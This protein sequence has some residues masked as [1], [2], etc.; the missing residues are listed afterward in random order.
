MKLYRIRNKQNG[1][2]FIGNSKYIREGYFGDW[3]AAGVFFRRIDTVK[4]HIRNLL[5]NW[6]KDFVEWNKYETRYKRMPP[7]SSWSSYRVRESYH[8]ERIQFLEV[9]IN[10]VTINGEEVIAA[11]DIVK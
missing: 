8:P 3:T 6:D 1:K 4:V 5:Y 7:S 10:D 9:V 2:F 11:K